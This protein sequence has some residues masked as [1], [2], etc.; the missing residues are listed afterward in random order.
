MSSH[1]FVKEGQEPALLILDA[2]TFDI[3]GPLL[4][5][6]PLVVVSQPA[7]E[8]VILWNIKMD[9]VLA[10][11]KSVQELGRKLVDQAPLTILSHT[12]DE[13]PLV[14]ALYFL[15]RKKQNGVNIFSL[16]PDETI[17]VAE[18]FVDQLQINIIDGTSKWS[19]VT[20]GHFEKWMTAKT[21]IFLRKS[22]EHQSIAL[23]GLKKAADHYE[24]LAD[25]MIGLKSNAL[26]WVGEPFFS[27]S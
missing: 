10:E 5:W 1:H 18:K 13:S 19:G 2:L 11:D 25:G 4:E 26:F 20:S 16:N 24:C 7:V 8:D 3:A 14:N 15:I 12:I 21:P 6:A 23:F 9:V 27:Q 22:G 17:A